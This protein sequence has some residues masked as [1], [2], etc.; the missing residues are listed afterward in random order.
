[1]SDGFWRVRAQSGEKGLDSQDTGKVNSGW[2]CWLCLCPGWSAGVPAAEAGTDLGGGK[3][4][5]LFS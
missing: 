4:A 3:A 1:M 2:R 5:K